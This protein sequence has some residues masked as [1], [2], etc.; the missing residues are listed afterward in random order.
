MRIIVVGAGEVGT[1]IAS[2]LSEEHDVVIVEKDP[3]RCKRL[4]EQYNV[5]VVQGNGAHPATLE[6]A[7]LQKAQ[8]LVAV[9]QIDS[10]NLT[11]CLVAKLAEV[12]NQ[13]RVVRIEAAQL[14]PKR[15]PQA[16]RLIEEVGADLVVDPDQAVA[17]SI[18]ERLAFGY[19]GVAEHA[20]MGD[21]AAL[22]LGAQVRPDS[23]M[24]GAELSEIGQK[25][26]PSWPYIIGAISRGDETVIPRRDAVIEAGDV[27]RVVCLADRADAFMQDL[28]LEDVR[29]RRVLV[30]GGGRTGEFL[31]RRLVKNNIRVRLVERDED[32]IEELVQ[33]L[34]K[35]VQIYHGDATEPDFLESISIDRFDAVLALTGDD[36]TN[37]L[38][39]LYAKSQGVREAITQLHRLGLQSIAEELDI[40]VAFSPRTSCANEVLRFVLSPDAGNGNGS[41]NGDGAGDGDEGSRRNESGDDSE[42][43][44]VQQIATFLTMDVE[45][46]EFTV[47]PGSQVVD[48]AISE[49]GLDK[50][51]LIGA[52]IRKPAKK[53]QP[54][55]MIARG[56][57]VLR[58][59]DHLLVFAKHDDIDEVGKYF[60]AS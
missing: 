22:V 37:I 46:L 27:V 41:G 40:D 1:H 12:E 47:E 23:P 44:G 14:N 15:N 30:I 20:S 45:V 35:D 39:C 43:A 8:L 5:L 31:S 21:G 42:T 54:I 36:D 50:K 13:K 17:E 2:L 49:A 57:T 53:G 4:S 38:S 55:P 52:V 18:E 16:Q 56:D 19:P 26:E 48:R 25:Y 3:A 60:C 59:D 28:G 9:T 24:V 11:A 6:K 51:Y 34:P 32:R 29:Y 58:E 7:G 33:S 10:V